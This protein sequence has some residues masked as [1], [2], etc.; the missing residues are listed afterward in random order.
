MNLHE[1]LARAWE[2]MPAQS[3]RDDFAARY[4][5][6]IGVLPGQRD[7]FRAALERAR[8]G[9]GMSVQDIVDLLRIRGQANGFTPGSIPDDGSGIGD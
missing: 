7:E 2:R 1:G 3:L 8:E 5:E 6:L 4:R 9:G